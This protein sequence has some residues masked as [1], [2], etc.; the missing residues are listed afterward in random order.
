MCMIVPYLARTV[1]RIQQ[2]RPSKKEIKGTPNNNS[3]ENYA[4]INHTKGKSIE[5]LV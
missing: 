3:K 1:Q 4:Y 2:Q 5:S